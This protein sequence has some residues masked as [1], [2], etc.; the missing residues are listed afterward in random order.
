MEYFHNLIFFLD[1]WDN[2]VSG[3]LSV[4][5]GILEATRKEAM[6]EAS[7]PN[8]LLDKLISAGSVS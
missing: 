3:G 4:G 2:M 1:K 8:D 5:L 7:V 6:E